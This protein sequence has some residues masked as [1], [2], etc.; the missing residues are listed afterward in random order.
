[1][2]E[3]QTVKKSECL[4]KQLQKQFPNIKLEASMLMNG[5]ASSCPV[6]GRQSVNQHSLQPKSHSAM[7]KQKGYGSEVLQ[8]HNK[9]LHGRN[10]QTNLRNSINP[11]SPGSNMKK[12]T[13]NEIESFEQ[14]MER[15]YG[16]SSTYTPSSLQS[17]LLM[18]QA[19]VP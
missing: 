5:C 15:V 11:V 3:P 7:P 8:H 19:Q 9:D 16:H 10:S 6:H 18:Q 14:K 13:T 17:G 1:M 2:K 12:L 4:A